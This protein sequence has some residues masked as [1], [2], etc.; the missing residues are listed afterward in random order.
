MDKHLLLVVLFIS[1]VKGYVFSFGQGDDNRLG[2]G[3]ELVHNQ[4]TPFQIGMFDTKRILAVS[5]GAEHSLVLTEDI[6]YTFGKGTYGALGDG[7]DAVHSVSRPHELTIANAVKIS[8][9]NLFSLVLTSDNKLYAFGNANNGRLGDYEVSAHNLTVPTRITHF[10][11]IQPNIKDI[12]CG[13]YTSLVLLANGTVY[14]FG[15]AGYG[16]C[17]DKNTSY[18][19]VVIPFRIPDLPPVAQI[20]A[21]RLHSL[22]LTNAGEVFGLGYA[23]YGVLGDGSASSNMSHSYGTP[24]KFNVGVA[25]M[26]AAGFFHTIIADVRNNYYALGSSESGKLGNGLVNKTF[27]T[28]LFNITA[29]SG[30]VFTFISAAEDLTLVCGPAGGYAFGN[31]NF[32]GVANPSN[33]AIPRQFMI[34]NVAF[35][36]SK[37]SHSLVVVQNTVSS[38]TNTVASSGTNTWLAAVPIL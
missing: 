19:D 26:I 9:G 11:S 37:G 28:A 16:M 14:C 36:S 17:G 21:G 34:Q 7:I 4:T 18:H 29:L 3:N 2:D 15:A 25:T 33:Q 13:Y 23:V 10:D 5:A 32:I 27:V 12:S 38:S 30:K 8:A 31:R 20:S 1:I 24:I 22:F 6:L 35:C